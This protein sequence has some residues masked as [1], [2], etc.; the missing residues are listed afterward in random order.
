ML[1]GEENLPLSSILLKYKDEVARLATAL[2]SAFGKNER[3]NPTATED[4]IVF[5]LGVASRNLFEE[6]IWSVHYG[7]GFAA[8]RT[9]RTL[10]ECVVFSW[11]I[12]K[13]PEKWKDYLETM[14]AQWGTILQ[15]VPEAERTLP[16]VHKSISEKVPKY[17]AGKHISLNWNDDRTTYGMASDIGISDHF[18]SL[19]FNYTSAFIHPSA[20]FL[21]RNF[22]PSSPEGFLILKDSPVQ[23]TR[24]ALQITHDL[25]INAIRLRLKYSNSSTL[26]ASLQLCEKDFIDI[27]GYYPQLTAAPE[28]GAQS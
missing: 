27:W 6:V 20:I 4:R 13:H 19:A 23:E 5:A 22:D 10:Y 25:I 18:H 11:Y 8:L 24:V 1:A 15:N 21:L 3:S 2:D 26:R 7:F 28:T 17:A 16:E 12:N 9:A 14:Y